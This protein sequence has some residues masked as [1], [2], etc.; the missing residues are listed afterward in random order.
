M[1]IL[2]FTGLYRR[3]NDLILFT[4]ARDLGLLRTVRGDTFLTHGRFRFAAAHEFL[5]PI[6]PPAL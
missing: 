5:S 2:L 3:R 6:V 1:I 4:S